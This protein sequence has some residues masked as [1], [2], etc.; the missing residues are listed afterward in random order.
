MLG[1]KFWCNSLFMNKT[2]NVCITQHWGTFVQPLLQWKSNE[3]HIFWVCICSLRFPPCNAHE[4]YCHL[5]PAPLYNIF[6]NYLK[7]KTNKKKK[8]L[9]AKCVFWFSLQLLSET[10][11]IVRRTEWDMIKNVQGEH[12]VVPWLQTFITRKLRGIQAFFF[13]R[14]STQEVFLETNLSN[15]K[16]ICLYS[17]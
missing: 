3:Y 10:F 9:N 13:K 14:N 2:G 4:P 1:T 12:K 7:N 8:L 16:E 11:H 17:T 6:P 5:W 15:G